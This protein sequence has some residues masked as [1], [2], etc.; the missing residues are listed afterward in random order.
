MRYVICLFIVFLLSPSLLI[1]R[2]LKVG[3]SHPYA[4][5]PAAAS[6]AVPGD[7]IICYD[8]VIQGGMFIANLQGNAD[9][10][11]DLF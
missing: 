10:L 11:L 7:S 6:I 8:P 1:G 2:I 3:V 5:I 9:L 4:N